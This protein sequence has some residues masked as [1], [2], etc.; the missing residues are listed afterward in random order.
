MAY[1]IQPASEGNVDTPLTNFPVS[2]D[3]FGRMQDV[4]I[5]LLPL[6]LQY[7]QFYSNGDFIS[8]SQLVND[9]PDLDDCLHNAKKWNQLR[10]AVVAMEDFLLNQVD[11]LYNTVA[12][13]ALGIVDEPTEEQSS[14]VAYSA[15]KVNELISA[16]NAMMESVNNSIS[17]INIKISNVDNTADAD[18]NVKHAESSAKLDNARSII[19]NLE[20]NSMPSF[21][22]TESI[23]PGVTGILPTTNGGTGHD[24]VDT[25]PTSGSTKMVTSGGVY[26]A[27]DKKQN[28]ITGGISNVVA[29]NFTADKALISNSSGKAASSSVTSTELGYLSGVTSAVQTQLN[30]KAASSHNQAASTITAGTLAGKVVAN[31]SAV[32]TVTTKQVRNIFAGTSEATAGAAFSG[33]ANGDIYFQYEV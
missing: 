2:K 16:L 9:N 19:T 8:A 13:N 7:N 3:T 10:D 5:S 11:E 30:G 23:S 15:E 31:A 20:S 12:Q 27:L 25:T 1:E 14:N 4:T 17:A 18:K 29:Q 22:G 6:V 33:L 26:D 28:T 21:D 32:A 24:S